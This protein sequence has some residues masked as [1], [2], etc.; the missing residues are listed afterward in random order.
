[1]GQVILRF[2]PWSLKEQ[3]SF[4]GGHSQ[5]E[6]PESKGFGNEPWKLYSLDWGLDF[7]LT[8][9]V[10]VLRDPWDHLRASDGESRDSG[11]LD[12]D[13]IKFAC[14]VVA[15]LP[16]ALR[17]ASREKTRQGYYGSPFSY[18]SEFQQWIQWIP[19]LFIGSEYSKERLSKVKLERCI[20]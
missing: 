12:P 8:L 19:E 9:C 18:S 16:K 4:Q 10:C 3:H 15:V 6:R 20:S 14:V 5:P 11:H 13:G 7:L 2:L 17:V 1:M